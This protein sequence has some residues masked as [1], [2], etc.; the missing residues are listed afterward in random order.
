VDWGV[1]TLALL[2]DRSRLEQL[3]M[4]P[5]KTITDLDAANERIIAELGRIDGKTLRQLDARAR[6]GAQFPTGLLP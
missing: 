4:P 3:G 6:F 2:D 5:E 1:K